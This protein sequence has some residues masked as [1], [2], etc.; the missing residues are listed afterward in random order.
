VPAALCK[1]TDGNY[2]SG[3]FS[4]YSSQIPSTASHYSYITKILSINERR[5]MYMKNNISEIIKELEHLTYSSY[6][7]NAVFNDWIDIMLYALQRDD[8]QYLEIVNKYKTEGL[9]DI[10]EIGNFCK[11]FALLMLEMQKTSDDV[12]GQ[13]YMQWNMNNKCRGQFFT[14]TAYCFNDGTNVKPQGTD[15]R[16][17]LWFRRDACRSDQINEAGKY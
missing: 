3:Y 7:S 5:Y 1:T 8:E 13:V 17:L 16:S 12:L 4:G 14:P 10:R 11:A 15:F 2:A 9:S 6:N